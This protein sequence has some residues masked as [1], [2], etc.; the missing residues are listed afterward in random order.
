MTCT[1]FIL[2][3]CFA[4]VLCCSAATHAGFTVIQQSKT[5]V[6]I[7]HAN[8]G[9][10]V[11]ER[12]TDSVPDDPALIFNYSDITL[13]TP[14]HSITLSFA[15]CK[16]SPVCVWV[17]RMVGDVCICDQLYIV[18]AYT[19][20]D[21]RMSYRF[22][23]SILVKCPH[24]SNGAPFFTLGTIPPYCNYPTVM[25]TNATLGQESC[26]MQRGIWL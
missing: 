10:S 6:Y 17:A 16:K 21:K 19:L 24:G 14:L 4:A 11:H 12:Y 5:N 9:I 13:H 8:R 23:M 20:N 18:Q 1:C 15:S 26:E 2:L 3:C 7:P 22:E 25:V